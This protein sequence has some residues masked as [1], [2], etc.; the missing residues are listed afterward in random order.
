M[1]IASLG[2]ADSCDNGW[3]R[4]MVR[5]YNLAINFLVR[6]GYR[7]KSVSILVFANL[8]ILSYCKKNELSGLFVSCP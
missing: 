3:G 4:V 1:H 6:R 8:K 2:K 7:I 5:I